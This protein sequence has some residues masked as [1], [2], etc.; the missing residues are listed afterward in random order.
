MAN[1]RSVAKLE[2][3]HGG[4]VGT[5]ACGYCTTITALDNTM[6]VQQKT[7]STAECLNAL[8]DYC[9][10][11]LVLNLGELATI[12]ALCNVQV[13]LCNGLTVKIGREGNLLPN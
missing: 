2:N 8:L 13:G 5:C 1:D 3:N 4:L 12:K 9:G 7:A 6:D 10:R 11:V